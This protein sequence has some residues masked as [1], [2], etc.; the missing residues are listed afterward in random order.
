MAEMRRKFDQDFVQG[1][2]RL[3]RET[4]KPISRGARGLGIKEGM[5]GNW[6]TAD[7]RRHGDGAGALSEDERAELARPVS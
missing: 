5:L 1:A 3:V 4:G 6:V 2:V 7:R